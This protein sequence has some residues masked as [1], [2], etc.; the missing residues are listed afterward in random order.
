LNKIS[1]DFQAAAESMSPANKNQMISIRKHPQGIV[2][3]IFVQ[4]RSS[5]NKIVGIYGDA[6]KINITAP[7]VGGA[8]NQRCIKFLAKQLATPPRLLEIISGHKGRSKKILLRS[9]PASASENELERF[10]QKIDH[11]IGN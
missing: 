6:I 3:K 7:P 5:S 1:L 9:D 10:R 4:P 11:L 8:A 2:F